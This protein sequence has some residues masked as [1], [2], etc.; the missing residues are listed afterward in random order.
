M[1]QRA[2]RQQ[3]IL[4][5]IATKEIDTQQNLCDELTKCNFNVTQATVSR[6]IK[7]LR[8]CKIAGT[9]KKHRYASCETYVDTVTDRMTDLYKGCVLAINSAYNLIVVKTMRGNGA[10]VGVFVDSLQLKEVIGCVAGDDNVLIVVDCTEN[11]QMV[12]DQLKQFLN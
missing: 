4:E 2:S 11:T 9:E 12:E 7:D 6:D 5:L 3:K 10:A 1:M 8:L